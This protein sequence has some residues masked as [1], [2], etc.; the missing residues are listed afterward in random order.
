[1]A[2]VFGLTTHEQARKIQQFILD[3][4]LT[5]GFSTRTRFP[6]YSKRHIYW[7]FLLINMGD[8][9][10]G[11]EWLWVGCTDVV[12]KWRCGLH[13]DAM[14]HLS[15]ISHK[16]IQYNGVFEVYHNGEPVRRLF[17]KSEEWFAWSSGMFVWACNE[18]GISN[19]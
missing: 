16:I 10:N 18:L 12:A 5:H 8:Y 11:M 3:N 9:H 15:K 1:L 19:L 4:E 13:Q 14:D 6:H 2:I 17:Y 7:P